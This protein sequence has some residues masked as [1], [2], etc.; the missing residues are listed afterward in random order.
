[1]VNIQPYIP[2]TGEK[3]THVYTFRAPDSIAD[4]IAELLSIIR[5][6]GFKSE[7]DICRLALAEF[8]EKYKDVDYRKNVT[9]AI[10]YISRIIQEE[11]ELEAYLTKAAISQIRKYLD[12]GMKEAAIEQRDIIYNVIDSL[13]KENFKIYLKTKIR[14]IIQGL[15]LLEEV[16]EI[17]NNT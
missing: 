4:S 14:G 6:L 15:D 17:V 7:G 16:K 13:P 11:E 8:V 10:S 1:L 12:L 3:F 9:S 5:P 2:P